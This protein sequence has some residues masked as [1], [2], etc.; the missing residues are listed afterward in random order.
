MPLEGSALTSIS[1]VIENNIY[2]GSIEIHSEPNVNSVGDIN[3]IAIKRF[4]HGYDSVIESTFEIEVETID[5][6]TFDLRDILTVSGKR[7][8]YYVEVYHEDG[9]V[10]NGVFDNNGSGIVCE[11]EGLFI[12]DFD[13][14]YV[15]GTNFKTTVSRNQ[16]VQYATTLA[17][18]YPY[19]ISNSECDYFSGTSSG[20]F[21]ELTEDRKR[22]IPD[23]FHVYSMKVFDFIANGKEKILKTNDG[24]IFYVTID[25][26]PHYVHSEFLGMNVLEFNWTQ[27]DDLPRGMAVL[28]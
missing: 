28:S 14:Q 6:L 12:G 10:E 7:Y 20:L 17:S 24:L 8:D 11:L 3:K 22:F 15:A 19:R 4:A 25:A 5:D 23:T 27:T 2:Y 1:V 26:Q 18:K 9:D 13:V 21:L 16:Q